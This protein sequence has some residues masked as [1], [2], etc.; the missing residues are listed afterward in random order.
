M[1]TFVQVYLV[2]VFNGLLRCVFA[3][4]AERVG[5]GFNGSHGVLVCVCG[6]NLRKI[7][8]LANFMQ[9]NF[10]FIFWSDSSHIIR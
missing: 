10:I 6:S 4:F 2:M 3:Q 5:F 7:S 9:R 8:L 1:P